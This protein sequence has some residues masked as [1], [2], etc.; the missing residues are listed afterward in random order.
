MRTP[1][2]ALTGLEIRLVD[3]QYPGLKPWANFEVRLTAFKT[4]TLHSNLAN[5]EVCVSPR[6]LRHLRSVIA[7]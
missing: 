5:S 1:C 7:F 2:V 3:Y 4:M 6:V